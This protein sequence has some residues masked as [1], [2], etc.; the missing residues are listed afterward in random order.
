[1]VVFFKLLWQSQELL[2]EKKF[3]LV[4]I[5][6]HVAMEC[7][8]KLALEALISRNTNIALELFLKKDAGLDLKRSIHLGHPLAKRLFDFFLGAKDVFNSIEIKEIEEHSRIRNNYCHKG[9]I[10]TEYEAINCFNTSRKI[11]HKLWL[12][13]R[14]EYTKK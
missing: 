1:M 6:S 10:P 5:I 11:I 7:A 13:Q 8:T 12:I 2:D 4:V 9:N 14:A 3:E